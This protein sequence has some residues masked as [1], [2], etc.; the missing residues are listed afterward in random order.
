VSGMSTIIRGP[1]KP[2]GVLGAHTTRRRLFTDDD[3]NFLQAVANVLAGAVAGHQVDETQRLLA[4]AGDVLNRSL[5]YVQ[6]LRDL[7]HLLVGRV[8]DWCAVHL[9]DETGTVRELEVSHRDPRM[10]DLVRTIR[11]RYPQPVASGIGVLEV[12]RTGRPQVFPE[13]T[14]E[15]LERAAQSAEHL[16]LVRAV[17]MRSVVIVPM[18]ARGRTLGAI[19]LARSDVRERY[20]SADIA[21]AMQVAERAAVAVDNA[22]L[23]RQA[24]ETAAA[25]EAFLS[26]ASHELRTPLTSIVGFGGRLQRRVD[27]GDGLGPEAAEEIAVLVQ[28]AERMRR[29]LEMFLDLARIESGRIDLDIEPVNLCA[30]LSDEAR[31]VRYR[32]PYMSV[33]EHCPEAETVVVTDA[34]RVRQVVSNL[35]ENAAK[36]AGERPR[37]ALTLAPSADGG[38]AITVRD[39]GPGIPEQDQPHIFERF[40]QGDANPHRRLGMGLGLYISKEIAGRLGAQLT[41]TTAPGEGTEFTL[42]LPRAIGEGAFISKD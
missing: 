40:Y 14:D 7:A 35:L 27:R 33:V 37:V 13:I 5:D 41:F 22:S 8:A 25:R 28:E 4:D 42:R 24:Q 32:Y 31:L 21:L 30:L 6:T 29:T 36:Y 9:V 16:D 15:M 18:T 17:G 26:T 38:A 39:N 1:D 19:L 3:V 20:G 11:Q 23:Y 2:W 12:V 10:I 34:H